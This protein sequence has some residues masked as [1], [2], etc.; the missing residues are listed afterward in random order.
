MDQHEKRQAPRVTCS[1]GLHLQ[2]EWTMVRARVED[3]GRLGARLRVALLELGLQPNVGMTAIAAHIRHL[4][5]HD[6]VANL[7][8][9]M[10]GSLV[11]RHVEAVRIAQTEIG[12]DY[13]DIGCEFDRPLTRLDAVALGLPIPMEGESVEDA[14]AGVEGK[15]PQQ[16]EP[17][18]VA[19]VPTSGSAYADLRFS[20]L[21]KKADLG[22]E[23]GNG[24][25]EQ[26]RS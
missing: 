16:R 14:E 1:I 21:V 11:Q 17:E 3:V 7:R 26:P 2:G 22:A 18:A 25:T 9:E 20:L 23:P 19:G 6:V 24:Q 12:D 4:L 13:V 15:A 8:P 10:L 5:T